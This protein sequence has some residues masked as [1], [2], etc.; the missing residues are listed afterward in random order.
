MKPLN[1]R[2]FL[3]RLGI[4]TAAVATAATLPSCIKAP[5]SLEG[6]DFDP[7][8]GPFSEDQLGEMTY[9]THPA[10]GDKV[11]I[12]GYGMMRLP[13]VPKG[14]ESPDGNDLDQEQ[15][16]KLVKYAMDHGVN[17]YDTSPAY[18]KGFSEAA[19][20]IALKATGRPRNSYYIATKLSNFAPQQQTREASQQMLMNSLKYLQTDY[21]DYLLL[22]SIGGG[23][24]ANFNHRYMDNGILDWLVEQRKKGV[25]RNLGF[26]FHGEAEVFETMLQWHDEGRYHWDFVQ[27]QMN[28]LDWQNGNKQEGRAVNAEYL[29]E[30][31][32]KRNIPVVIM[33]PLLG[34]RLSN[35]PNHVIAHLKQRLPE[36]SAASWA[37]RFCGTY[38]NVLC[39]LSGMTWMEH[40][41]DNL[42]SFSPLIPLNEEEL[43]YLQGAARLIMKYPL[44]PCNDCKYCMPCPYGLDIP[45]I[46]VHYNKC[47][48]I[49]LMPGSPEEENYSELR[50]NY[51]IDYNRA[52]PTLRQADH[53][54]NCNKCTPHCP[55]NIRI[56]QQLERINNTIEQL[57]RQG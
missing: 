41:K 40:L 45:G 7:K 39:A 56:P 22:H 43:D 20:G 55:Q 26:S 21:I 27:I 15:I 18:C 25:I 11:S 23:G 32:T 19:T 3:Q 13:N 49:G 44:I 9:R 29:Y 53:C 17:Y 10:N 1:R 35:L 51:L 50:R 14:S 37:F 6:G 57:K 46:F 52:I 48:N 28:Y 24:M 38:P 5:A 42:R 16:N 33:E 30:E 31:L 4:G 12:L 34:G 8:G 2:E 36:M 47:V 54:V